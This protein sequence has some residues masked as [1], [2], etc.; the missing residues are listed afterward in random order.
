MVQV[1]TIQTLVLIIAFVLIS[2]AVFVGAFTE[3]RN[4]LSGRERLK[5]INIHNIF[6]FIYAVI[7]I[8]II[9]YLSVSC[10]FQRMR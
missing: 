1:H 10:L 9:M 6:R 4:A 8:T 5:R 2:A 3:F 7:A